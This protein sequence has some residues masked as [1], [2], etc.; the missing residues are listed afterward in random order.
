M[1]NKYNDI[2]NTKANLDSDSANWV[3]KQ[4]EFPERTIRLATSFSGIG[5]IEHAF[6]RLG[7]RTQ[8]QFAG[9]IDNDC[10]SAYLANYQLDESHWHNDITSF[11]AK[12]YK[13]QVD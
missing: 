13:G 3:S 7:L 6:H 4:F 8:L 9:D 10:K 5:A 11:D 12:P 1:K 2:Q